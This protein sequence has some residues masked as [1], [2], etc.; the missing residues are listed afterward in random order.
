MLRPSSDGLDEGAAAVLSL[1]ARLLRHR[2]PSVFG[3]LAWPTPIVLSDRVMQRFGGAAVVYGFTFI[4]LAVAGAPEAIRGALLAHEWGH[5]A[6]GHS[7]AALLSLVL[8]AACLAS[9]PLQALI[10]MC[11]LAMCV[12]WLVHPS[13]ELEADQVAEQLVGASNMVAA[14]EWAV[15]HYAGGHAA[16]AV[17][18]RIAILKR[19]A[20]S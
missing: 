20:R 16:P 13:R 4:G 12:L 9:P 17:A 2:R 6:R 19:V 7:F 15:A 10:V 1:Q 11:F 18:K 8:L 5:I 14:L 3:L